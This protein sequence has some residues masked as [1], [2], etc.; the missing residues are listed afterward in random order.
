VVLG[1]GSSFAAEL[2]GTTDDVVI[3]ARHTLRFG[4][5]SKLASGQVVVNDA[6]GVLTLRPGAGALKDTQIIADIVTV[7]PQAGQKP[8]LFDVFTNSFL[9][10]DHAIVDDAPVS[11]LSR[12]LPLFTFPSAP[13]VTP[14][15][16]TCPSQTGTSGNCVFRRRSGPV[17]LPAGD[18][19]KIKVSW[20][21]A[22]NLEGGVYN[23]KSLT[24][25]PFSHILVSGS[26][27]INVQRN[28]Y[29]GPFST[30]EPADVSVNPR[31]VVL[32]VAGNRVQSRFATVSA[33]ISA[34]DATVSLGLQTVYTGNLVGNKVLVGS[35][36][37]LQTAAPLS[38][39]CL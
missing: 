38:S 34:P 3:L 2:P 22:V 16:D 32:N 30:F 26:T 21:S 39:P 24:S 10:E 23:I 29:F 4:A 12:S 14:G 18:Y 17:T 7:K 1:T 37:T 36:T 19:G 31:C 8:E 6:G 35:E 5:H 25:S 20:Y 15:T 27:T 13:A 28:V 33:S 9:G 11:P